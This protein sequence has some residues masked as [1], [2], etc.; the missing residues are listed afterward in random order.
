MNVEQLNNGMVCFL[1]ANVRTH[2]CNGAC[3]ECTRV[4]VGLKRLN[5]DD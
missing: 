4:K 3:T 1:P 2:E 5:G